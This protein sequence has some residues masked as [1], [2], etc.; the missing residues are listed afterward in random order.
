MKTNIDW[1]KQDIGDELTLSLD[2]E[3]DRFGS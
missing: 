2:V 1:W 3:L